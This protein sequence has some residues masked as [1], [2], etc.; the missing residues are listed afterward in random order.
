LFLKSLNPVRRIRELVQELRRGREEGERA[1]RRI[2]QPKLLD[3]LP[4]EA[5][6]IAESLTAKSAAVRERER[7]LSPPAS[8][9][10]CQPCCRHPE[11]RAFSVP[12]ELPNMNNHECNL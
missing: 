7:E 5:G 9:C 3:I 6:T 12:L 2:E 4:A 11:I 8:I 10:R 1:R